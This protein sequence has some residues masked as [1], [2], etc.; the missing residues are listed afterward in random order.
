MREPRGP[1][2][3]AL[4]QVR[5]REALLARITNFFDTLTCEE[6]SQFDEWMDGDSVSDRR[7]WERSDEE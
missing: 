6:E 2:R 4:P 7:H 1:A 3:R 5:R